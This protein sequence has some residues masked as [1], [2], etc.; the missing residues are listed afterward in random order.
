MFS[1]F[2]KGLKQL[3]VIRIRMMGYAEQHKIAVISCLEIVL[4][5]LGNTKYNLF[6]V[7]LDSYYGIAIRECFEHPEQLKSVLKEVYLENYEYILN[8]MKAQL[9]ELANEKDVADFFT[10]ME[11]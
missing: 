11:N 8:E 7:K 9:D 6:T 2:G 5:G 10:I 1:N 4:M 3:D